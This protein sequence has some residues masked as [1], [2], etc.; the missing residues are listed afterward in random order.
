MAIGLS[1]W[2]LDGFRDIRGSQDRIPMDS[3]AREVSIGERRKTP[4]Q[5]GS[6]PAIRSFLHCCLFPRRGSTSEVLR[7]RVVSLSAGGAG[8]CPLIGP[9]ARPR[10][11]GSPRSREGEGD[12]I[13]SPP[14]EGAAQ[15]QI[16]GVHRQNETALSSGG[17]CPVRKGEIA[18]FQEPFRVAV[19]VRLQSPLCAAGGPF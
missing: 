8:G 2:R 17:G 6:P 1:R 3:A 19:G 12:L 15:R 9:W 7:G 16:R 14:G 10:K 4:S 18:G 11:R 13:P 5:S